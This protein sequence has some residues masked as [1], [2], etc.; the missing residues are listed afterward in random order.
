MPWTHVKIFF[1][2]SIL[3]S[4]SDTGHESTPGAQCDQIKNRMSLCFRNLFKKSVKFLFDFYLTLGRLGPFQ[5]V[6][7]H[8]LYSHLFVR[9][10]SFTPIF[11]YSIMY[12]CLY[13]KYTYF[14]TEMVAFRVQKLGKVRKQI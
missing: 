1:E 14:N 10:V 8:A 5:F 6:G 3:A 9:L 12:L 7:Y 4:V 11:S 2:F 13:V